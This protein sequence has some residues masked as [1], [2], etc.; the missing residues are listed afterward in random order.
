MQL[1]T[2]Q[3]QLYETDPNQYVADEE[4]D[5][6]S[7]NA[8]VAA[9]ALLQMLAE[10]Y[11]LYLSTLMRDG[12]ELNAGINAEIKGKKRRKKKKT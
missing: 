2:D 11:G 12:R 9:T 3:A 4:D 1:T 5:T 8:R 7:Y 10:S 6:F